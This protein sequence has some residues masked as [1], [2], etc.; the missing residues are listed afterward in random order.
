L[1]AAEV[2]AEEPFGEH[3]EQHEAAGDD[4]LDNR[5][6]EERERADV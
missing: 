4:R 2:K 3:C 6:L 5:E 1:S